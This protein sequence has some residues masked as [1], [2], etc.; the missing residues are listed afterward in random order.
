MEQE[1]PNE[2]SLHL[3]APFYRFRTSRL[4]R[5]LPFIAFRIFGLTLGRIAILNA[6]LRKTIISRFIVSRRSAG[7]TLFRE[8]RLLPDRIEILDDIESD[9]GQDFTELRE[10]GFFSTI[11]MASARY[12]RLQ[13]LYHAWSGEDVA[14]VKTTKRRRIKIDSSEIKKDSSRSM[15]RN[16]SAY[17]RTNSEPRH[18]G[19]IEP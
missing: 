15:H 6:L 5:P 3:E 10:Y 18:D 14:S 16:P 17:I 2:R 19:E 4:M 13:D 1:V 11:Y 7:A 12:F 8:V 9:S